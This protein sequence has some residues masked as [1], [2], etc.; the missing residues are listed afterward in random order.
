MV[1]GWYSIGGETYYFTAQGKMVKGN[2]VI[3]GKEYLFNDNG[4]YVKKL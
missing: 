1:V 2:V 4:T 3:D